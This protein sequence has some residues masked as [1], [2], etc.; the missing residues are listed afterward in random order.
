MSDW[1]RVYCYPPDFA[2]LINKLNIR[3]REALDLTEGQLVAQR[4]RE[5]VPRGAFDLNHLQ[6]IHRHLFQD[7][8]AWAGQLRTVALRKDTDQFMAPGRLETGMK[9]IHERLMSQGFLRGLSPSEFAD[10]AGIV[11]GD[12]NYLHPFREG[13]GRTQLL[14]LKQL[15]EFAGH[16]LDLTRLDRDAWMQASR[17]AHMGD[18]ELMGRCIDRALGGDINRDAS[19]AAREGDW[20]LDR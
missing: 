12:I 8:Y 4:I 16:R 6:A 5:G 1:D 18:F 15:A 7:I 19:R 10:Q 17:N 20:G 14:Y 9:F 2:V 11:I 13:N 3:E